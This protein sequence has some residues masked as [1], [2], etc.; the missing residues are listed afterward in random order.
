MVAATDELGF[1]A[2]LIGAEEHGNISGLDDELFELLITVPRSENKDDLG[3]IDVT[4][5]ASDLNWKLNPVEMRVVVVVAI[6]DTIV[7]CGDGTENVVFGAEDS[8]TDVEAIV[9][10][11]EVET[12]EVRLLVDVSMEARCLA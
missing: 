3:A 1:S 11:K 6:V 10:G 8:S 2:S 4:A 9:A 7:D 5:G 12:S